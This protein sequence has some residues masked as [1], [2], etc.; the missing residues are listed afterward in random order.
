MK[1][2]ASLILLLFLQNG[3][4]AV[5][6]APAQG[7]TQFLA[8][9]RP[10]ALKINGKGEG[11]SG[12]LSFKKDGEGYLMSGEAVVDMSKFETGIGMRDRHMKETYLEVEKYKTAKLTLKDVKL[13]KSA[14]E[15]GG[16]VKCK[17]HLDLHG[18]QQDVD[19]VVSLE[20]KEDSLGATSRFTIKLSD[21]AIAV[22][23]YAGITVA[24]EVTVTTETKIPA[25][26]VA[27]G[28]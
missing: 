18:K 21:F 28:T 4:A 5:S 16:E 22:P 10:S 3:H 8:V 2:A 19:V 7:S 26:A 6:L 24:D 1:M 27:E 11:P 20:K 17:G 12:S 23:K 15:S 14:V 9:G 25:K 13:P